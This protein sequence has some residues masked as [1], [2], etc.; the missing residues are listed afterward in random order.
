MRGPLIFLEQCLRDVAVIV[1]ASREPVLMLVRAPDVVRERTHLDRD[2]V[3]VA[4]TVDK[5]ARGFQMARVC[6][7]DAGPILF[8]DILALAIDAIRVD[9]FEQVVYQILH[10]D[11]ARIERRFDAFGVTVIWSVKRIRRPVRPSGLRFDDTG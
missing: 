10:R 9:D 11:D 8:T 3:R 4:A 7:I 2:S 6:T 1:R 5:R